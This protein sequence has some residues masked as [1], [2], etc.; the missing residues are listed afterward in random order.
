V[1]CVAV[2]SG[3]AARAAQQPAAEA[4]AWRSWA[5]NCQG[6]HRPDAS[7]TADGAPPMGDVVAR[8]LRTP[9]GREYLVRV[10]GVATSPLDD[11]DTA[12]LLNWMLRRFDP[13][14]VP[15]DFQPYTAPEVARLRRSPLHEGAQ[16]MRRQLLNRMPANDRRALETG[17]ARAFGPE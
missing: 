11:A 9:G 7:G 6:C 12:S 5:L 13:R 15:A 3:A 4:P 2:A 17:A 10:P 16:V 1:I 14:H 8:F